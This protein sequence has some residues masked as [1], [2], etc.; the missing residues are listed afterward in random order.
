MEKDGLM[1][2]LVAIPTGENQ[3]VLPL[4]GRDAGN[5][6]AYLQEEAPSAVTPTP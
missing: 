2:F 6:I 1:S 4:L 3:D 5:I